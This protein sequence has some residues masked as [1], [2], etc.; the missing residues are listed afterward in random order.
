M[1]DSN[2]SDKYLFLIYI[3]ASSQI[4]ISKQLFILELLY[5]QIFY[6]EHHK[7]EVWTFFRPLFFSFPF[8]LEVS[9]VFVPGWIKFIHTRIFWNL[10]CSPLPKIREQLWEFI[11]ER[12]TSLSF[13]I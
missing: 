10:I 4:I 9:Y 6:R 12:I 5:V 1:F 2:Y 8:I 13:N 11:S 3:I 7:T